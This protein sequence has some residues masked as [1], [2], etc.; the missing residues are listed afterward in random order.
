MSEHY[1]L[2]VLYYTAW[3]EKEFDLAELRAT[4]TSEIG[5]EAFKAVVAEFRAKRLE[6]ESQG[7][8]RTLYQIE[9]NAK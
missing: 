8:F 1:E 2:F 7:D 6:R 4:V 3:H 9:R 5:E